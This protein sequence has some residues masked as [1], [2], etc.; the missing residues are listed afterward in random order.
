MGRVGPGP[1]KELI[2]LTE[3]YVAH[4]FSSMRMT[5]TTGVTLRGENKCQQQCIFP[6]GE[7]YSKHRGES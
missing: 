5:G 7:Q 2:V 1:G 6:L 4:F 3:E